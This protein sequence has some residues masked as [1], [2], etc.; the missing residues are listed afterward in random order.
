MAYWIPQRRNSEPNSSPKLPLEKKAPQQEQEAQT[1][2]HADRGGKMPRGEDQRGQKIG[3]CQDTGGDR[4][5]ASEKQ[6]PKN[7]GD[8][9]QEKQPQQNLLHNTAIEYRGHHPP[10]RQSLKNALPNRR[11]SAA[12]GPVVQAEQRAGENTDPYRGNQSVLFQGEGPHQTDFVRQKIPQGPENNSIRNRLGHGNPGH[13]FQASD[14]SDQNFQC[15]GFIDV[16]LIPGDEPASNRSH[17]HQRQ[18]EQKGLFPFF[19][20]S[21]PP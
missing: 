11:K 5:P 16:K 14:L 21:F 12:E 18:P 13:S 6:L 17:R 8:Q 1:A 10:K 20:C 15:P 9:R 7:K 3:R 19:H 2:V 4:L